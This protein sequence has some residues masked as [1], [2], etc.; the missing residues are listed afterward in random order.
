[1]A[2]RLAKE[3]AEGPQQCR[4][5]AQVGGEPLA[6]LPGCDRGEVEGYR[7]VGPG[8]CPARA[9]VPPPGGY[10]LQGKAAT[11]DPQGH[12]PEVLP[13]PHWPCSEIGSFL[14]DRMTGPQRLYSDEYWWCNCG[15]R[16]SRHHL[17]MECRAWAPQIR[18]LWRRVGK[19]CGWEHPR[20]AVLRWLWKDDAVG[21][22]G[23]LESTRVGCRA[24]A[25]VARE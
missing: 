18:E 11:E 25:E 20:V 6:P 23:F 4:G 21:A 1:M 17:F 9:P 12:S 2:D 15:R 14:H 24:S 7:S 3:A 5:R 10:G 8:A 16:Q 13:A 19:D 22:V